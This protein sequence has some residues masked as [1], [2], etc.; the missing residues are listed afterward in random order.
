M[1]LQRAS[2]S[3][4]PLRAST[5]TESLNLARHRRASCSFEQFSGLR[6][7]SSMMIDVSCCCRCHCHCP[8]R[9]SSME[10]AIGL[11]LPSQAN[12][13]RRKKKRSC[14]LFRLSSLLSFLLLSSNSF[15]IK[16]SNF[17]SARLASALATHFSRV[18]FFSQHKT[19]LS[20][21][22]SHHVLRWRRRRIR[23]WF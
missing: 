7:N 16:H 21:P 11:S 5:D 8:S 4:W 18:Q 10:G 20:Q 1:E 12:A 23:R 22:Y 9:A 2:C 19:K 3:T 6:L 14:D 13:S 17:I 15:H